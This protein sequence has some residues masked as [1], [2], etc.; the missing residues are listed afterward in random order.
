MNRSRFL[1]HVLRGSLAAGALAV[2]AV[3]AY[4]QSGKDKGDKSDKANHGAASLAKRRG[5]MGT[6]KSVSASANP[7][8][9]VLTTK[10]GDLT[11]TTNAS[12]EYHVH[13][14]EKAAFS[15]LAQGQRVVVTGERPNATTLLA[16]RVRVL[17]AKDAKERGDKDEKGDAGRTVTVGAASGVSIA[18]NGTGSFSVTPQGGTAVAFVTTADTEYQLK[19]VSGLANG[20][21]VRVVST[22]NASGQ[23]VALRI[24]VPAA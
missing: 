13:G 12:T 15:N 20:Q 18:A 9:F 21:T 8:S 19:G 14:V 4:A 6:V 2:T 17:K 24:R 22:K 7:Q 10:Q 11:V 3:P 16:R 1:T 23:N 5:A